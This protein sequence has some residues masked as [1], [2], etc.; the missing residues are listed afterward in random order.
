MEGKGKEKEETGKY[1]ERM[2]GFNGALDGIG[3]RHIL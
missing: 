3:L 1:S 2:E